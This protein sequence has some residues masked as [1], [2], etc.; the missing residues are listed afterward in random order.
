M[1]RLG[2]KP[3]Q[4]KEASYSK[5]AAAESA[6]KLRPT[7]PAKKELIGVDVFFHWKDRDPIEFGRKMESF[8]TDGLKLTSVSNRGVKV[9]P[10]GF[11]ET[12]CTDH[13]R[14]GFMSDTNHPVITH[15]QIVNL[16]DRLQSA[17]FDFI[18]I[19]N[20]YTFDGQKGFTASQ[21]E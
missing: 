13:W 15:Q 8:N 18:K 16:L 10:N 9:Y 14:C 12:F 3:Q 1:A 17:G 5:E 21:G 11:E 2:Q 7:V 20:L 6:N 19:E 4:L